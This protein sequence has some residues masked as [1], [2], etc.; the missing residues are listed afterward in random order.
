MRGHSRAL[1]AE[2]LPQAT[3]GVRDLKAHAARI[4]R[5]VRDARASFVVTHR[6]RAVGV[7]LPLDTGD[8]TGPLAD[9]LDAADAWQA[10]LTA[11]RRL[12]RRFRAGVGG[13]AILSKARR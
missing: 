10:F 4:V 7:I 1:R 8:V 6:G 9:D 12:E 5:D 11:G 2:R 3:V 13:V